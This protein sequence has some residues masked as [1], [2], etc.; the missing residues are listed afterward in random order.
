MA[1]RRG[2]Q[3]RGG[4]RHGTK[5]HG[6]TEDPGELALLHGIIVESHRGEQQK[7]NELVPMAST[8]KGHSYVHMDVIHEFEMSNEMNLDNGSGNY[9]EGFKPASIEIL[10]HVK[11]N[12]T[13][14]ETPISTLKGL[15]LSSKSDQSFSNKE[16]RKAEKQISIAL[17]EFYHTLRLLKSY[18]FINL[19]AFSKIMKK[20]DKLSYKI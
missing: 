13:T 7:Q 3:A 20:Y 19:L 16:L 4:R 8:P 9:V 18:S 12:V 11:I 6:T 5:V 17:K 15:L 10:D 2:A 14:P 1:S